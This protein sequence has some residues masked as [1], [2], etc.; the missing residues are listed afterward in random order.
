MTTAIAERYEI[1]MDT[2]WEELPEDAQ[3]TFLF[4]TDGDRVI[5]YRNRYGRKR[6]YTTSFEGIVPN[7]ERRYKG[8]RVRA[9]PGRSRS[10]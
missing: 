6:S 8:D 7:L 5:S 10:T 1:D 3:D 4:G 9:R 2:P